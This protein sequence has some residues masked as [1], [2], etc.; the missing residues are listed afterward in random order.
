METTN[1]N[2]GFH[3]KVSATVAVIVIFALLIGGT[4]A[5]FSGQINAEN[6]FWGTKT[7]PPSTVILH[8]DFE[9]PSKDVYVENIGTD[10]V[11]V[12]VKLN[13]FW[14]LTT[15]AAPS[16][17]PNTTPWYTHI[18]GI[19][20]NGSLSHTAIAASDVFHDNFIWTWGDANQV[21]QYIKADSTTG[22]VSQKTQAEIDAMITADPSRVTT[23][24]IGNVICAD[25]YLGGDFVTSY[26]THSGKAPISAR[27]DYRGWIYD[28]D[29]WVYWSQPLASGTATSLLL[30]N[31]ETVGMED[32]D[33]YYVIDVIMEAVDKADLE[34]MWIGGGVSVDPD[35][36]A[37]TDQAGALGI[38][39][40][41]IIS[42]F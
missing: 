27:S 29:G 14:D 20:G 31:V 9:A 30:T 36:K 42:E 18:P 19:Q 8:D 15:S 38:E 11:Y 7:P 1:L 24:P 35:N 32:F 26:N 28:A 40:L 33:F 4:F 22:S 34:A 2:R 12:R 41:K 3:K 5:W 13:E 25:W 21:K 37:T 23:T 10:S 39:V 17:M 6:T 16:P